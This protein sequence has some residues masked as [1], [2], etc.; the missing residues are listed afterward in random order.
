M[1]FRPTS[2]FAPTIKIRYTALILWFRSRPPKGR[3]DY[4]NVRCAC[5]DHHH[6]SQLKVGNGRVPE[7]TLS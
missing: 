2:K 4:V 1:G 5:Y 3:D 7:H 6:P